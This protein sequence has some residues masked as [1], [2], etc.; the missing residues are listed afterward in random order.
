MRFLW[1]IHLTAF[2]LEWWPGRVR[3]RWWGLSGGGRLFHGPRKLPFRVSG[4]RSGS[5]CWV[6]ALPTGGFS[7]DLDSTVFQQEGHEQGSAKGYNS[8]HNAAEQEPSSSAANV[9]QSAAGPALVAAQWR[10]RSGAWY[11][12]F[13]LRGFEAAA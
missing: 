5:G 6:G 7:L 2:L 13:S 1:R 12:G 4:G 9:G 11:H 10:H 8:R 3:M